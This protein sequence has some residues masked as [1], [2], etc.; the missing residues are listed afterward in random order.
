MFPVEL[1]FFLDTELVQC[2]HE[3]IHDIFP[4]LKWGIESDLLKHSDQ[5]PAAVALIKYRENFKPEDDCEFP[6][7]VNFIHFPGRVPENDEEMLPLKLALLPKLA[8]I[9]ECRVLCDAREFCHDEDGRPS[10]SFAESFLCRSGLIY[11]GCVCSYDVRHGAQPWNG[12]IP[13]EDLP[14]VALDSKGRTISKPA[15]I[16]DWVKTRDQSHLLEREFPHT[17]A[18][19]PEIESDPNADFPFAE[20]EEMER[21]EKEAAEHFKRLEAWEKGYE[22]TSS[23]QLIS[24]GISLPP[25][26]SF[27]DD[28]STLHEKLW[29]V[30][31]GLRACNTYLYSTDHLS[32]LEL[33]TYLW[34]EGLNEGIM[35]LTG[36]TGCGMHLDILGSGDTESTNIS[37]TYYDSAEY[38]ADWL[39]KFPGEKIPAHIEKPHDRD[40]F[41]PKKNY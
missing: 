7:E 35:D 33:Y 5:W 28:S 41:L 4:E 2:T 24:S 25:P 16:Q 3:V 19:A 26:D 14:A 29:E 34:N 8:A 9:F 38:R 30:I 39:A 15:A 27:T 23:K 31:H 37:L 20:P 12:W 18:P 36:L 22:T 11:S 1:Q 17:I 32:D 40:R 21:E 10:Y 6:V 13:L